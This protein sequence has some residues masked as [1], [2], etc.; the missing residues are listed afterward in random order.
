MAAEGGAAEGGAAE[1]NTPDCTA[2]AFL[3]ELA[4][5]QAGQ[6]YHVTNGATLILRP[7]SGE[8]LAMVGSADYWDARIDGAYNIAVDGQRQPGS[9]FKPFTYVEALR[10]NYAPSSLLLDVPMNFITADGG[11]YA[12]ENYDRK[13]HGPVNLPQAL[14]RRYNIPA[15]RL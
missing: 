5:E 8:I 1:G 7:G 4:R 3:P 14:Q 15:G 12:P 9:S 11:G 10:L 13:F 6:D 2:A